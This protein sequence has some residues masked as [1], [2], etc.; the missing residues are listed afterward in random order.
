ME[1][2]RRETLGPVTLSGLISIRLSSRNRHRQQLSAFK[3]AW[4][5][6]LLAAKSPLQQYLGDATIGSKPVGWRNNLLSMRRLGGPLAI[7]LA[8]TTLLRAA[9]PQG[10]QSLKVENWLLQTSA[11]VTDS[12]ETLS[13]PGIEPRNWIPAVVPGTVLGSLAKAKIV[14]DPD[15][16]INLRNLLG[17]KFD[18]VKIQADTPMDSESEFYVPW[19]YRAKFSVPDNLKGQIFWLHFAGI[20]YRAD[21]WLNGHQITQSTETVGTWRVFDFNVTKLLEPGAD[22]AIAVRVYP[23]VKSDDLALSFVDW[24]PGAPDRYM[25]LFRDVSILSTGP[26]AIRYPTVISHLNLPDT[27][28]AQLTVAARLVNGTDEPQSGILQ[29]TIDDIQFSQQFD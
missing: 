18:N 5:F 9:T 3:A 27:S 24:N 16:G 20:N 4:V 13:M 22:N 21:I 7:I 19:W 25:G 26:V 17:S 28:N 29:G 6:K 1:L 11:K 12:G 10:S 8:A 15:Y 14:P 2:P 23:P